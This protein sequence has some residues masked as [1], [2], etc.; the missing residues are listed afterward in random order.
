MNI[1]Y[2]QHVPFEGL[3]SIEAWAEK[4]GNTI[5]ATRFYED[6]RLPFI[7]L[8]D[9][10]IVLG[11]PM[12]ANDEDKYSWMRAEKKMIENAIRKDKIVLGICLGAQLI[13]DVL[14]AKV[15]PNKEKEIGWFPIRFTELSK[16]NKLMEK[17][18]EQ[19][20]PFHWHGDTFD[21][22]SGASHLAESDAC[23]YQA[24][25][26]GRNVLGLQFHLEATVDSVQQF[27]KAGENE[28][29]KARYIQTKEEIINVS[30]GILDYNNKVMHDILCNTETLKRVSV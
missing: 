14:G 19:L 13:A 28:L 2:F 8:F 18:P 22:P 4:P 1:H 21:L 27:V 6:H 20:T 15:Y 25:S 9:M 16:G 17:V 3:G 7:D 30:Q 11:G 12:G 24:Y 26:Y 5:T 23:L 29:V 10:L